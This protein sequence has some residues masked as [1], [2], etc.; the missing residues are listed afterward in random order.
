MV[1]L[2]GEAHTHSYCGRGGQNSS[3]FAMFCYQWQIQVFLHHRGPILYFAKCLKNEQTM[4][5]IGVGPCT[6]SGAV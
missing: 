1:D 5:T 6:C 4:G 2:A 3:V